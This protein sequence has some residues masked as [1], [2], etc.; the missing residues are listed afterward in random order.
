MNRA[1]ILLLLSVA[2]TN[3]GF[4]QQ[5]ELQ[6]LKLE[7]ETQAKERTE[8][9]KKYVEKTGE[10]EYFTDNKSN[11]Y[12]IYDIDETGKPIYIGTVNEG[13]A[14]SIG[15][16]KL[17]NGSTLGFNLRGTGIKIGV[18]DGGTVFGHTDF[19]TRLFQADVGSFSEHATHVAGTIGSGGLN[20][21][22]MG[23]A[24]ESEISSYDWNSDL[25]EMT[26]R[27]T[28]D[29]NSLLF[30]NH[31][32]GLIQGWFFNGTSWQWAG[33]SSVN[34]NEDWRFGFYTTVARNLDQLA[35]SAPYYSIFW[36]AG[37]DRDDRGPNGPPQDGNGGSGYDCLAQEA[38]AKNIF[39]IGAI[40]KVNNYE[41]PQSV[42][43]S[44]FSNW[45]PTDD[46]RIKPDLVT[47]GVSILSTVLN[48]NYGILGGTS[49]ASPGAAG[50][51]LLVQELYKKL[52]GKPMRSATLKALAIQTAKE[53][54]SNPG[55]DFSYGWGVLDVEAAAKTVFNRDDKNIF[56]EENELL[57]GQ[58][59]EKT[60]SPKAGTKITVTIAWTD[61]AGTVSATSVD[62]TDKKLV[63]DLDL[64][65]VDESNTEQF[66]WAMQTG[67]ANFGNPA[68]KADN[69]LDN[70]E[71][72]EFENAQPRTYKVRIS[73]KGTLQ[74]GKQAFSIVIKY[75]SNEEGLQTLY[76]VGNSGQWS[77]PAK[78]SATSGG[79]GGAGVPNANTKVVFDENSF[80]SGSHQ[81]NFAQNQTV[82]SVFSFVNKP[83][84]FNLNNATLTVENDF[85]IT[86]SSLSS[87]T[88]GTLLLN[89]NF[90]EQAEVSFNSNNFQNVNLQVNT[91]GKAIV[92]GKVSVNAI[93]LNKGEVNFL[94]AEV[95][96]NSVVALPAVTSM[97]LDGSTFK[98]IANWQ[99]DV[100]FESFTTSQTVIE[101]KEGADINLKNN[102]FAGTLKF[103]G[104]ENSLQADEVNSVSVDGDLH[105]LTS[106]SYN[107]WTIEEG[108]HIRVEHNKQLTLKPSAIIRGSATSRTTLQGVGGKAQIVFQ[109]RSKV[110]FDYLN[111]ENI[112]ITGQ[113]IVNAGANSSLVNSANWKADACQNILFPDYE[114]SNLCARGL[115]TLE[116]NSQGEITNRVW[117]STNE[118]VTIYN[119]NGAKAYASVP[120]AGEYTITLAISNTVSEESVAIPITVTAN[121]LANNELILNGRILFSK[122]PGST[123]QWYRDGLPISQA[124]QRSYEFKGQAGVY[125]VVTTSED[126]NL[127]S[128]DLIVTSVGE[129]NQ[130]QVMVWPVP[131]E[132]HVN[133]SAERIKQVDIKNLNGKTFVNT[134]DIP[135]DGRLSISHLSPGL[136]V[137]RVHTT[138]GTQT[139][140][141]IKQ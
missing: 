13:L 113:S 138:S 75:E 119:E 52:N 121:S 102:A 128:T 42:I 141:L 38:T 82:G 130:Q 58:V 60:L 50:G 57:N 117:S 26:A 20:S 7:F 76:W 115:I 6:S 74:G 30:S 118:N 21:S 22:A 137:I 64:R 140:K 29:E 124:T 81:V 120:Q 110:C 27:V 87:T 73:H 106:G 25:S 126:C 4:A 85:I 112:D 43:M 125:F 100:N 18:W 55:P 105:I 19:G 31:S 41:G 84:S 14:R 49:M 9:V 104:S 99:T 114:V 45:G 54:G 2:I 39:S 10:P 86:N 63:N 68:I 103:I 90:D 77:D 35:F 98:N 62:P 83:V 46:G 11:V 56:I 32:Y 33:N 47:P 131:A 8:R 66:P 133:I 91:T 61:P 96:A 71:K 28:P 34:P 116:D 88:T 136:Y 17:Q 5:N 97:A 23:M 40:R 59:Y 69:Q 93:E 132:D 12:Q 67:E 36:A 135:K 1:V 107:N 80:S 129:Q 122:L 108:S 48:N 70:V 92:R 89:A 51:L 79:T 127:K 134:S 94:N 65:L 109:P 123:Y 139:I 78:W 72:L 95:T 16:D 53:A 24:P 37:N 3:L 101:A 15:A 111:V 44:D